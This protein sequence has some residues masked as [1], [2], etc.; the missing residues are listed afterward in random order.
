MKRF[1]EEFYMEKSLNRTS[2]VALR[3]LLVSALALLVVIPPAYG[4]YTEQTLFSFSQYGP[5]GMLP[6]GGLV[7]DSAGN[8]YG[9]GLQGGYVDQ[10]LCNGG[11]GTV[12]KIDTSGNLTVLHAFDS[13]DGDLPIAPLAIDAAGNLYSTTL[14]G[15]VYEAGV[16]FKVDPSGNETV[17]HEFTGTHL[18]GAAPNAGVVFDKA[19][20]L[21]GTTTGG[22]E[23]DGGVVY[24]VTPS[25]H[26]SVLHSF[27][28]LR[29]DG[30]N[31]YAS[32]MLDAKGNI[33]GTTA[34]GGLNKCTSLAGSSCGIIFRLSRRGNQ[35]VEK[36]LHKFK[37]ADGGQP[38]GNL[39]F[40]KDGNLYG[41]AG[42][43]GSSLNCFGGCGTIFELTTTGPL[44]TL[45]N[46]DGTNG[47]QHPDA[48]LI[49]DAQG[50]LYGTTV[51]DGLLSLCCGTAF[52]LSPAG[53]LTTIYSPGGTDEPQLIPDGL[54]MDSAGN[55]YGVGQVGGIYGY[56]GVFKLIPSGRSEMV[57]KAPS[58][59]ES[60]RQE[61]T[62][63]TDVM[64]GTC[65]PR[66]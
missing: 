26:F 53:Q 21:Y 43:G 27:S 32:V 13:S 19:G 56:G 52:V 49:W 15:G 18:D 17:L 64:T 45:Y 16:V 36:I 46:F 33:Y 30:L 34:A 35:W 6:A 42:I 50:N 44:I 58:H 63:S 66:R 8:V 2:N 4:Q 22:G 60:V 28:G 20:N 57:Q 65:R 62:C 7:L 1:N 59:F 25:G 38:I 23:Y 41:T 9:T 39:I 14:A 47:Q 51:S 55:L 12:F 31:P 61:A 11:C 29:G 48:G 37:S 24:K 5:E 54:A 3:M 10:N 40:D